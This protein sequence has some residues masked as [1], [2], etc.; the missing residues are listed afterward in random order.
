MKKIDCCAKHLVKPCGGR[1]DPKLGCSVP[2]YFFLHSK[3]TILRKRD[4]KRE[5]YVPYCSLAPRCHAPASFVSHIYVVRCVVRIL[6]MPWL[7]KADLPCLL[8][9][10]AARTIL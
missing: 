1:K 4:L 8:P 3:D 9:K 10:N 7:I 5:F 2:I 6:T